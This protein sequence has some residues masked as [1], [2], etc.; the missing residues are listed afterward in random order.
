MNLNLGSAV[1]RLRT[2]N[3]MTQEDAA[4]LKLYAKLHYK[5]SFSE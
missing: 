3:G 5:T 2:E 4:A 1:K